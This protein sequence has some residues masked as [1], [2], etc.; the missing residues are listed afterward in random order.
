[1]KK[2]L[3]HLNESYHSLE[4]GYAGALTNGIYRARL[5]SVE[6]TSSK[7]QNVQIRWLLEAP[8]PSGEIGTTMK[9]SPLIERSMP[10][11][12]MDLRTLGIVLDDLNELYEILPHLVWRSLN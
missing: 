2:D 9:F 4:S 6:I 7:N 12:R 5:V 10:Y 11:L 8:T 1:M 3:S